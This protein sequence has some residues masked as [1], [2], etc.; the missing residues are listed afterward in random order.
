VPNIAFAAVSILGGVYFLFY[1]RNVDLF[2]V[3]FGGCVFYFLPLLVGSVP[4]RTT[5]AS[6]LWVSLPFGIYAIGI[7]VTT[8]V[9][10]AAIIFDSKK[11]SP[12]I[13]TTSR[14]G[15]GLSTWYLLFSAAGLVG[16]IK[17]G[18]IFDLDKTAVLEQVGY[19]FVLFETATALA[20]VDAFW[21]RRP[22]QLAGGLAFMAVD[23]VIGFR[24]MTIMT[25]IACALLKLGGLGAVRPWRILPAFGLYAGVLF[26]AMITIN[27]FRYAILPHLQV[28]Q[29]ASTAPEEKTTD[30]TRIPQS[31]GP[32][33]SPSSNVDRNASQPPAAASSATKA[34]HPAQKPKAVLPVDTTPLSKRLMRIVESPP[35]FQNI[36]PF[37]TQAILAEM[38]R[39][40]FSCSPRAILNAIYVVPFAGL[41]FGAPRPFETEFKQALF[42]DYKYG[43]AG[44]I[45]AEA[46]CRFGYTGVAFAAIIFVASLAG[47]QILLSRDF[48]TAI[49]A[50]AL[51]G[52]FLAFYVHRNDL[53]F[54]LLLIRRTLI[55]F[56][57]AWIIRYCCTL[58]L[59]VR[60]SA[61]DTP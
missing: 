32:G 58:F 56:V 52:A 60:W 22:W 26:L 36:E 28:F 34:E 27:P 13:V 10:L 51:S 9:L 31:G 25:F 54:E 17:S 44:N 42:P 46:F 53:L 5:P 15:T 49:P 43:V 47:L 24:M 3:A 39:Q 48:A 30:Q 6:D 4:A 35:D 23:L 1:R 55:V 16:A 57:S 11:C 61:K 29:A 40:D 12:K 14:G 33:T 45:W 8:I 19:W 18:M 2:L 21:H 37:V 7:G 20:V 50:I 38:I 41:F 59:T